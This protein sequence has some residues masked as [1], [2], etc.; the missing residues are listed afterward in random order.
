M[1]PYT[2]TERPQRTTDRPTTGLRVTYPSDVRH[3]F[4]GS[5]EAAL[6]LARSFVP[7]DFWA[8]PGTTVEFGERVGTLFVLHKHIQGPVLTA[9]LDQ[10]PKV[11]T[12]D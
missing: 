12:P 10:G 11:V 9:P 2:A 8:H 6:L 5:L 3:W 4:P 1:F 7:E